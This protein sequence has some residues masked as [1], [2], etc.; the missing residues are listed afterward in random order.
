VV[1]VLLGF[2]LGLVLARQACTMSNSSLLKEDKNHK[3]F[4]FH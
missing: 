4:I 2:E 3:E 1:I